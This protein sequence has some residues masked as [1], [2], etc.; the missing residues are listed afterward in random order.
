MIVK[1]F[2][3][4]VKD[5]G[6]GAGDWG[7]VV[8]VLDASGDSCVREAFV[9]K[10][11]G[12]LLLWGPEGRFLRL[13]IRDA[14]WAGLGAGGSGL[15]TGAAVWVGVRVSIYM[16]RLRLARVGWVERWL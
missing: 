11:F 16:G 2:C 6:L 12:L 7:L 3:R 13:K 15:G 4:R 9:Y 10:W 14:S 5:L 1:E 8:G